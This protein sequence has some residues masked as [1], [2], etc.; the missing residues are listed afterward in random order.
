MML[1]VSAEET[2]TLT[3]IASKMIS[4][5]KA[6]EGRIEQFEPYLGVMVLFAGRVVV[7]SYLAFNLSVIPPRVSIDSVTLKLKTYKIFT[8]ALISAYCFPDAEWVKT[9]ITWDTKP[10]DEFADSKWVSVINEWYFWNVKKGVSDAFAKTGYFTVAL[11]S[12]LRDYQEGQVYFHPNAKLEI[13]YTPKKPAEEIPLWASVTFG[14]IVFGLPTIGA[15]LVIR[16]IRKKHKQKGL[17]LGLKFKSINRG[18]RHQLPH[19]RDTA[20]LRR[21]SLVEPHSQADLN[22]V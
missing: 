22:I 16:H 13:T 19:P 8:T 17:G 12:G 21:S 10:S 1:P 3:P 4:N 9:G 6:M 15:I 7:N 2:I 18:N 20:R 11:K 14:F 5:D